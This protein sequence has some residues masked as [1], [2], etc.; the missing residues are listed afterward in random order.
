MHKKP[1]INRLGER[2]ILIQWDFNISVK[3][4]TWLINV[5]NYLQENIIKSKVYI[6]NTYNS[7]VISYINDIDNIYTD[8][9]ALKNLDYKVI[10]LSEIKSSLFEIPV[11]YDLDLGWD[12]EKIAAQKEI[13]VDQ[14]IKLHTQPVYTIYFIGFLP[15]FLYLGG[16]D[17]RLYFP[18]LK[19]PRKSI[20]K[21]AVGIAENQ[22]GIYPQSSPGGWQI[23][24]NCPIP[25]FNINTEN[26]SPF[27][28]GDQLKFKAILRSEY[29]TL[30]ENVQ[31]GSYTLTP[32]TKT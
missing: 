18:R 15:G 17:K 27:L 28:P 8:Y 26:P 32:K 2:H 4:L 9:L 16:L 10:T 3:N 7:L 6:N 14:I 31:S 23:I 29:D 24:G 25:I 5:K 30:L 19:S 12:L 20:Q 13:D 22:T 11:C 21:G 1:L